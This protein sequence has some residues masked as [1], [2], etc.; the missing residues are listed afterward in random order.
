LLGIATFSL[1]NVLGALQWSI[2]LRS[3][4]VKLSFIKV[5]SF[6][7]VGLF[8]NN[9]LIG[10]VGGDA[11]R[12]YDVAKHA[13]DSTVAVSSVVF[14][15]L[16][17][18]FMLTSIAMV[19][20]LLWIR[21]LNSINTV[22]LIAIVLV[23]WFFVLFFLF[24]EKSGKALGRLFKPLLPAFVTDKIHDVYMA[25]NRY[26]HQRSVMATVFLVSFFVQFLRI[27][28]HYWAARAIGAH[29]N[30]AYFMIFIPI[31][32]LFASLPISFG[33][34]GVREQSGVALF[35]T[36]G[37]HASKVVTFEFLAYIIG[38]IAAIPG[39]I[40]FAFR[41]EGQNSLIRMRNNVNDTLTNEGGT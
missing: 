20:S 24:H 10:Y 6:Y 3:Q 41:K 16:V 22:Y 19:M 37:L 5:L 30:L 29:V 13:G 32:A 35:T 27:L 17:G 7:H 23:C 15:R 28:T 4:D 34:I 12:M 39:G 25:V 40:L 21:K 18:F 1:S 26:Q 14:D 8:F 2:L 9:F 38:I 36:I 31:I 11:F 33:G